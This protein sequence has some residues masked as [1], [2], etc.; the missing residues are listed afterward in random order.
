MQ[1]YFI[2]ANQLVEGQAIITGDDVH[3]IGAVMR[4]NVGDYF[5]LCVRGGGSYIVEICEI[6]KTEVHARVV[7]TK[8]ENAELPVFVTISQA[9]MKGDKFDW[10]L[11]KATECGASEF[12][13]V[14]M[15]RSVAKIDVKKANK[16]VERWQKITLEAARQSHRQMVPDVRMPVDM[17]GL[18][19]EMGK[20]DMC[21]FA[22][23][24][25]VGESEYAL[26]DVIAGFEPG[27]RV[28]VLVGPEGGIAESE[29]NMLTE[30]GFTAVGLGPRILRTETAPIYVMSVISYAMELCK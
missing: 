30:A 22:Y 24:A 17:K 18:I 27:M 3:H 9:I 14:A 7:E 21:L 19:S 10:V 20:Y 4:A 15:K 11:Q 2:N 26:A 13:P 23:E 6:S 12:I 16:K 29:V 5:V 25:H 1:R 28:L 8:E